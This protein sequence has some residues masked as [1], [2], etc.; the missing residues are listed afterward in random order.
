MK[1]LIILSAVVSLLC[2]ASAQ[3][4][5]GVEA[6]ANLSHY[7]VSGTRTA[8]RVGGMKPGFQVGVSA[9][10]LMGDRWLLMSGLYLRQTQSRMKL[11]ESMAMFFPDTEIKVNSLVVPLKVGYDFRLS[12]KFSLIPSVGVYAS[13]G[14]NAGS[15]SLKT[16][17]QDS[18]E[19]EDVRLESGSWKPMDGYAYEDGVMRKRLDPFRRWDYGG[20]AGLKAVINRHY[21]VAFDYSVGLKKVQ[22]QNDLRNSVFRLSVGYRF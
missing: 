12:D 7:L 17:W 15:C 4:K 6:G 20:T 18:A 22:P 11:G 3:V 1:R 5:V 9:D 10:W 13:Y 16:V 2:P 19:S 8:D 21:T 14:F